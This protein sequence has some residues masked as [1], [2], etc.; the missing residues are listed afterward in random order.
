MTKKLDIPQKEELENMYLKEGSTISSLARHFNT[1]N[2][3]VR[4][5]LKK[6]EIHLKT[7][8]EA[9]TQANNRHRS[10]I[11]PDKTSLSK[12]YKDY[13]IDLL[14]GH[15]NVGQQTIYDWLKEYDIPIRTLSESVKIGKEKQYKNIQFTYDFLDKEYDRTK[16]IDVLAKTLNVSRSHIRSQLI[17]NKIKIKPIEPSYRSNAEI[18]LYNYLTSIFVDDEWIHSD[19]SIIGPYELDIVNVS[20]KLAIEY[21]GLYWHSELSSGK[22]QNYH[23]DK[24]RKCKEKG[25]RL[26]TIFDTD[27]ID[28]VKS[29]LLKLLG[30]TKKIG[31]RKT[32]IV[33]LQSKD[34]MKFHKKHH[35]H[36]AVGGSH[37]YGLVY[38][39]EL[40]MVSSFGKNRYSDKYQYE[41]SRI[42]S[43]SNYT[44]VGGVS[45]LIK[46][47]IDTDMPSSIITFS[48]LRFGEGTVYL[49]CNFERLEDAGPNYWYSKKYT[50]TLYSRVKFQK[51]K[52][53]DILEVYDPL[54]TEFENMADNDWD[55]IWDCGNAKY[56]WKRN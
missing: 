21:C 17:K 26:I 27:D 37:H 4:S 36:S 1:S 28:K 24:Y 20:K 39:D 41:C 23:R 50:P 9:S 7:H 14:E 10:N 54:K 51:H 56:I 40:V 44:V 18:S 2:P 52:L 29:L 32:S 49:N 3:T 33:K 34:A 8:R 35:L 53:K 48:D 5:W 46:Y 45:K 13:T 42:T 6:Y 22:K 25:Y 55:R 12:L 31:A 16:S 11:K 47:F 15:F 30:S 19:K 43:H 38:N